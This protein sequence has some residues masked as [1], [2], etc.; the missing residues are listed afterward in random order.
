MTGTKMRPI[1]K[2]IALDAARAIIDAAVRPIERERIARRRRRDHE[3]AETPGTTQ[4]PHGS[5]WS[6]RAGIAAFPHAANRS[7]RPRYNDPE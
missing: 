1:Q 3:D 2:T 4:Q 5:S 6:V 7:M